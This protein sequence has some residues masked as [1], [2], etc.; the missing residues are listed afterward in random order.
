[1]DYDELVIYNQSLSVNISEKDRE[2]SELK[3][4]NQKLLTK[5]NAEYPNIELPELNAK[6]I[7]NALKLSDKFTLQR[8]IEFIKADYYEFI[9]SL[10][11]NLGSETKFEISIASN[12]IRRRYEA[13]IQV[14]GK[15][16]ETKET[17]ENRA[18][19][20]TQNKK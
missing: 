14:L 11:D 19:W 2:I 15:H 4:R 1:M 13:W 16:A 20:K 18:T 8:V 7:T 10:A 5:V 17:F 12:V 6:E 9:K 3:E